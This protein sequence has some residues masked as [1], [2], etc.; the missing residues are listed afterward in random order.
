MASRR[1]FAWPAVLVL[2]LVVAGTSMLSTARVYM[3]EQA[4][5][6]TYYSTVSPDKILPSGSVPEQECKLDQIQADVAL[7]SGCF[8]VSSL[9]PGLIAAPLYTRLASILGSRAV[10]LVSVCSFTLGICCFDLICYFY[11]V[12]N[13]W[14]ILFTNL[15]DLIGGG[16]TLQKILLYTYIAQSTDQDL[17]SNRLYFVS[18]LLLGTSFFASFFGSQT[19]KASAWLPLMIGTF[20]CSLTIP[21]VLCLRGQAR[22]KPKYDELPMDDVSRTPDEPDNDEHE[23]DEKSPGLWSTIF[24]AMTVDLLLSLSPVVEALKDP[25][26]RVMMLI[27]LIIDISM[28]V[29]VTFT[30]F[31][32]A[33]SHWSLADVNAV[34]SFHLVVSTTALFAL[35]VLSN[36]LVRILH[37]TKQRVDMWTASWSTVAKII[38]MVGIGL[39]P[40]Q[41]IC[42]ASLMIYALGYGLPDA[43]RSLATCGLEDERSIQSLYMGIGL[44]QEVAGLVGSPIWTTIFYATL[45]GDI[46]LPKGSH[47]LAAAS[48]L[49]IALAM[50]IRALAKRLKT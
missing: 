48:L 39:A 2:A 1:A 30:Q 14:M 25:L 45:D 32:S 3:I 16:T 17:L 5:C 4:L 46:P 22:E 6:R 27:F 33:L 43:L 40:T 37:S 49:G 18:V 11:G 26:A 41:W 29:L 9:V 38:G 19:M 42:F 36:W 15:F 21:C 31:V 13:I 7:L 50:I 8:H 47:F 35:P 20:L 24:R 28:A 12:F 34:T 23:H 44:A 10:L